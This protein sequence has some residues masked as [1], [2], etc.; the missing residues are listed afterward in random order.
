MHI[1]LGFELE[2]GCLTLSVFKFRKITL[3]ANKALLHTS[4]T[5]TELLEFMREIVFVDIKREFR[6]LKQ[7]SLILNI[8]V[9]KQCRIL[10]TITHYSLNKICTGRRNKL[11]IIQSY[12]N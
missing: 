3:G 5:P 1:K 10:R 12:E 7:N 4:G 11:Q 2:I 8:Y 9:S 6:N